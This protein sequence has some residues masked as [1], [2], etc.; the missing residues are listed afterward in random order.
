MRPSAL[1]ELEADVARDLALVGWPTVD[2]VPRRLGPSGEPVLDVL[3]VGAGHG[4]LA[5]ASLLLRERVSNI[6]VVDEQPAGREGVWCRF[7]RMETLR[8]PKAMGGPDLGIPSLTFQAWYEARSGVAAWQA[9]PKIVR[10]DWQAYLGWL[11]LVLALPVSN[12]VRFTG[13]APEDGYLRAH[14]VEG[15][16]A[17]SRLTRKLVLANG[18]EASGRWVLPPAIATLPERL[19]AHAADPIDF[20]AL[21]G[22]H[23]VVIGAGASAFDNAATALEAG[24]RV[25]L[26]CRRSELP[27]ANPY[28]ALSHHGYLRHLGTLD[29]A[30]RWRMMRRF[31]TMGEPPPPETWERTTRHRALMLLTGAPVTAARAEGEVARLTTPRGQIVAELVIAGTG[32][33]VDLATR[34]ELAAIAA[35]ALTWG[36]RFVPPPGLDDARL[37]RFPYLDAGMAF[38]ERTAGAAPWLR[39]VHCLTMGALASFG[40]SGAAI[41]AL[42]FA[43][44]RVAHAIT[45]DLFRAD[46]AHHEAAFM[47]YETAELDPVLA[48]DR[49]LAP[50]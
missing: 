50:G 32:F 26:L 44:P 40:P 3:I 35:H 14:L 36:D 10:E 23:V 11:R 13:V 18:I 39:D 49:P 47:G 9:L 21:A 42:R 4:G 16:F 24:A 15:G 7:A 48:R 27:L 1:A 37:A 41:N 31:L 8:T 17:T 46:G 34:P 22:R 45:A 5:T 29:D 25:T 38:M 20:A 43:V 33:E 12:G 30:T 6:L 2:W 28:K 19:R